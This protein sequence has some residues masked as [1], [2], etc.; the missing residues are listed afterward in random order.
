MAHIWSNCDKIFD[1]SG[2][3][4]SEGCEREVRK[5]WRQVSL[6]YVMGLL[7]VMFAIYTA[8]SDGLFKDYLR[9]A[10]SLKTIANDSRK[11]SPARVN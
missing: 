3:Y 5:F 11:G 7:A 2:R 10:G 6:A 9:R 1:H 4:C 8:P